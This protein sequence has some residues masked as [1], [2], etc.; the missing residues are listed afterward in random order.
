[1]LLLALTQLRQNHLVLLY[2]ILFSLG[3][4]RWVK[5]AVARWSLLQHCNIEAAGLSPGCVR[6]LSVKQLS[7]KL[8]VVA[9]LDEGSSQNTTLYL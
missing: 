5:T 1:M 2:E 7:K 4:F 3:S 6:V 8:F 9:T